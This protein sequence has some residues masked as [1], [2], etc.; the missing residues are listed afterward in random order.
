MNK[1]P[2]VALTASLS[3]GLI[4]CSSEDEETVDPFNWT[5]S[6]A[7]AKNVVGKIF[8]YED[9]EGNATGTITGDPASDL[10][11][12]ANQKFFNGTFP[13]DK[14]GSVT[15]A[16]SDDGQLF[17]DFTWSLTFS[18]CNDGQGQGPVNGNL[19]IANSTDTPAA[20]DNTGMIDLNLT[21]EGFTITG[22]IDSTTYAAD[23]S[24]ETSFALGISATVGGSLTATTGTDFLTYS[25]NLYPSVGDMTITG[26]LNNSIIVTAIDSTYVQIQVDLGTDGIIESDETVL[27]SSL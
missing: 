1:L 20:G 6:E 17:G 12:N 5:I 10:K 8:E 14:S 3:I 16:Y 22:D 2:V 4:G 13:C 23:G 24:T 21:A 25:G 18:S 26:P 9:G 7:N 11:A 15:S 27:W 19:T